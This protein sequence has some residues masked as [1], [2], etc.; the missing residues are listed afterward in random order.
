MS[1]VKSGR[2]DQSN[3]DLKEVLETVVNHLTRI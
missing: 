1:N 2:D 3:Y